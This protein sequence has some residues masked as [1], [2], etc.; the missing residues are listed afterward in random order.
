MTNK[1]KLVVVIS[2]LHCGHVVGLTPPSWQLQSVKA[3]GK[4]NKHVRIQKALWAEYDKIYRTLRTPDLLI[5]NGDCIDGRAYKSGGTELI[6]TDRGEQ[7]EMAVECI[8]KFHA[9][10]IIMT[11]GTSYHASS[12]GEDWELQIA[13]MVNAEKIGAHEW[14]N[15]N[16]CLFDVKHFL[17]FSTSPL[18]GTTGLVRD[19]VWNAL[20]S[21]RKEQPLGDVFIRSHVHTYMR[22]DTADFE[23]VSTP[24]L[25]G[26]GSKYGSRLCSRTVDWGALAW[27]V[28]SKHDRDFQKHIIRIPEQQ[29][30]AV[31][32]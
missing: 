8:L 13:D 6:T 31:R 3:I 21:Q 28:R 29:A 7:C 19:R 15:V 10:K 20:W 25:Q 27:T 17:P 18:T 4:R 5:V 1:P 11:F 16:G 14:I 23:A 30:K 9:R 2:D 22:V 12:D 26:M 24:A 32:I